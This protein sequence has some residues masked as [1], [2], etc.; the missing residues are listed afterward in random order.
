MVNCKGAILN[1]IFGGFPW[2]ASSLA[3]QFVVGCVYDIF[4][5]VSVGGKFHLDR[6]I[7]LD[8]AGDVRKI[9]GSDVV[10][11]VVIKTRWDTKDS[12][13]YTV[14]CCIENHCGRD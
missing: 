4:R 5:I 3:R 1:E 11:R 10:D 9:V 14:K 13:R 12:C 7:C 6:S 8:T 2:N